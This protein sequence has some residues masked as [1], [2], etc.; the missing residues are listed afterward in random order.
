MNRR[1]IDN[2]VLIYPLLLAVWLV[3]PF[4]GDRVPAWSQWLYGIYLIAVCLAGIF[5]AFRHKNPV[6]GVLSGLTLF[7]WPITLVVALAITFP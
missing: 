3:T 7:A 6:L 2:P 1:N 5:M 4:M